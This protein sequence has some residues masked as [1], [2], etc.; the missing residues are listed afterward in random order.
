VTA[1]ARW[2]DID[3]LRGAKE[4]RRSLRLVV[5]RKR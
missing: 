4:T 3:G 2:R 5:S 1:M